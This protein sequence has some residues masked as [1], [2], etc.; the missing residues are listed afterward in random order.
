[1]SNPVPASAQTFSV[2]LRVFVLAFA[3][4]LGLSLPSV[5]TTIVLGDA[6]RFNETEELVKEETEFT[7]YENFTVYHPVFVS[8]QVIHLSAN[9]I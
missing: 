3:L 2:K 5:I 1:M 4:W 7:C 8:A 9:F 6:D